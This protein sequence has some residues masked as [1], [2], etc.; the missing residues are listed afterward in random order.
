MLLSVR[1]HRAENY[2]VPIEAY[3]I[4]HK[5]YLIKQR[6]LLANALYWY[7]I[8]IALSCVLFIVGLTPEKNFTIPLVIVI[9]VNTLVYYLNKLAVKKVFDPLIEKISNAINALNNPNF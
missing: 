2:A 5:L 6:Q 8:P 7:I 9:S 4:Q 3:L 1:R